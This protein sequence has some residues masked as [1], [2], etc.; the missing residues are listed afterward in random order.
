MQLLPNWNLLC[1]VLVVLGNIVHCVSQL[2]LLQLELCILSSFVHLDHI[3]VSV[4]EIILAKAWFSVAFFLQVLID[5]CV[6]IF[7]SS[8]LSFSLDRY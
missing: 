7:F 5:T 6:V 4:R 1:T 8:G 3:S 2:I